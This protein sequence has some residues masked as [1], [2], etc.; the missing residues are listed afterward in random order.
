[1]VFR[2]RKQGKDSGSGFRVR[3]QGQ[4]LASGFR[5]KIQGQYSGSGF[6]VKVRVCILAVFK[7]L[8]LVKGLR[9]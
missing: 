6:I 4:D 3:I 7:G 1:M 8:F 5:V 9:Y 2:V